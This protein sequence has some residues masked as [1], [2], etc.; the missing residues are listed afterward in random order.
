MTEI[1]IFFAITLAA[2]ASVLL[3]AWVKFRKSIMFYIVLCI[4][5]CSELMLMVGYGCSRTHSL[6]ACLFFTIPLGIASVVLG[7]FLLYRSI[8]K[9][10]NSVALV[11]KLI[12]DGSGDLTKSIEYSGKNEIGE[13]AGHFNR[14]SSSLNCMITSIKRLTGE[15][16]GVSERLA[17]VAES[18]DGSLKKVSADTDAIKSRTEELDDAT[19]SAQET[20]LAFRNFLEEL[21]NQISDQVS[22]NTQSAASIE[23]MMSSIGNVSQTLHEKLES[24]NALTSL[25]ED[26]NKVMNKTLGNIKKISGATDIINEAL[27]TISSIGARTNLLAMNAAI[28]AAHAGESGKGFSVVADEVRKLAEAS[29]IRAKEISKS[30]KEIMSLIMVTEKS[31]IQSGELFAKI[32]DKIG[33]VNLG[34]TEVEYSV[35]EISRESKH[36]LES[37]ESLG[38]NTGQIKEASEVMTGKV[39]DIVKTNTKLAEASTEIKIGIESIA[40]NISDLSESIEKVSKSGARNAQNVNRI[41]SLTSGFKV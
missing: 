33:D 37:L 20:L 16:L 39:Q 8:I 30:M 22:K 26:G 24:A 35:R 31:S 25:A 41:V 34:M 6:L 32:V 11:L 2:V 40:A 21:A 13:L 15:N 28:E 27:H 38:R 17:K 36:I 19:K 5:L 7:T 14:F 1:I 12:A 29:T 9:P 23:E 4:S 3:A 18:S 10:L